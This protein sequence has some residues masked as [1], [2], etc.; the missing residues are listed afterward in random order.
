M[1]VIPGGKLKIFFLGLSLL[2]CCQTNAADLLSGGKV[3][4]LNPQPNYRKYSNDEILFSLTDGKRASRVMWTKAGVLGWM[5]SAPISILIDLEKNQLLDDFSIHVASG[6]HGDVK[7][8]NDIFLYVSE[9]GKEFSYVGNAVPHQ[10]ESPS[11]YKEVTY[12]LPSIN[13]NGRYLRVEIVPN[14]RY[15]FTDEIEVRGRGGFDGS[16]SKAKSSVGNIRDDVARRAEESAYQRA[17]VVA[18]VTLD[19]QGALPGDDVT[20]RR[21]SLL[22]KLF[23][24]RLLVVDAITPWENVSDIVPPKGDGGVPQRLELIKGGCGFRGFT[25]T[26]VKSGDLAVSIR[27]VK[28]S[29]NVLGKIYESIPVMAATSEIVYDPLRESDGSILIKGGTTRAFLLK[30]CDAGKNVLRVEANGE[31]FF[32]NTFSEVFALIGKNYYPSSVNWAYSDIG[33]L[34]GRKKAVDDD[35][36]D[37]YTNTFVIPPWGGLPKIETNDFSGFEKILSGYSSAKN[38]LLYLNLSSN[39]KRVNDQLWQKSFI[40]WYREAE[41][42]AKKLGLQKEAL[43]IYPFDEPSA[44]DLPYFRQFVSWF[45]KALPD[46]KIF[47]TINN[48][49]AL[50]LVPMVDIACFHRGLVPYLDSSSDRWIYDTKGPG[51]ANQPYAYYRLLPWFSFANGMSGVGFWSY[52]DIYGTA[53]SDFDG[54]S[55][56]YGVIYESGKE[57]VITSRRWE[58]WKQGIEEYAILNKYKE[59]FGKGAAMEIAQ[60]VVSVPGD[61]KAADRARAMMLKS[62]NIGK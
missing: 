56:D 45:R 22:G 37:H 24:N 30:L 44:V 7:L 38:I 27:Q 54:V 8:P 26:N 13:M 46:G 31:V 59:K 14:G 40:R 28:T 61:T 3:Y 16:V 5:G 1:G 48:P 53:W 21:I 49:A 18:S 36:F 41:D 42:A 43:V 4:E 17:G 2:I 9:D 34:R 51:K 57:D 39:P 11:T 50:E 62:I 29:G 55:P 10:V 12:Y 32:I 20:K 25:I 6:T 60:S 47:T 58:A 19:Q 15:F 35:L 52:G 33:A 23:P